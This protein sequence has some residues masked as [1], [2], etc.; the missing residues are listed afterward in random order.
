MISE[1]DSGDDYINIPLSDEKKNEERLSS[2]FV[3]GDFALS[4]I[5]ENPSPT[6]FL[7]ENML[8]IIQDS[9]HSLVNYEGV[10]A[11]DVNPVFKG[12]PL[13]EIH[14]RSADLLVDA[15]FSGVTLANNHT[16]DYGSKGLVQT[17]KH[18]QKMGLR[19]VGAGKDM[20]D[21]FS[22]IQF[23]NTDGNISLFNFSER[24]VHSY[25]LDRSG[26]SIAM[27]SELTACSQL[28]EI[29]DD[30]TPVVAICH[31]GEIGIPIPPVQIQQR[32]RQLIDIGVDMVIG[33]HPHVPQ[34]WE[35]YGDG[36]IF[37]SLGNFLFDYGQ[38][39]RPKQKWGL[40]LRIWFDESGLHNA[41]VIPIETVER[42]VYYLGKNRSRELY[43]K[44]L[45]RMVEVLEDDEK[46]ATMWLAIA[47][48][49]F[50]KRRDDFKD[51]EKFLN[52]MVWDSHRATTETALINRATNESLDP[53]VVEEAYT[54]WEWTSRQPYH[55]RSTKLL[56][57][58][59][60]LLYRGAIRTLAH[61]SGIHPYL[62][63]LYTR[64]DQKLRNRNN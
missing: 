40:A 1:C 62:R 47:D 52:R 27:L 8:N 25:M 49:L 10:T 45:R 55:T 59:S 50:D 22:P 23:N 35:K 20:N 58:V 61:K 39:D 19:T 30:Q 12:G 38:G 57:R 46:L 48:E 29:K 32:Y 51:T 18:C 33:H 13:V 31:G 28:T 37:Y 4:N 43:L 26:P 42:R 9:D 53:D 3:A 44:R 56:A 5:D 24:P 54:M 34:G 41:H 11:T 7:S 36:V 21:A 16:F 2:I 6:N 14:P 63:K 15:G 17:I 60:N 64:L